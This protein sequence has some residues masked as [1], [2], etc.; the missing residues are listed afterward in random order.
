MKNINLKFCFAIIF[1]FAICSLKAQSVVKKQQKDID[2]R[3]KQMNA[4]F[5]KAKEQQAQQQA[6][7]TKA[8]YQ[9]I[10]AAQQKNEIKSQPTSPATKENN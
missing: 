2:Q 3:K 7:K 1:S 10:P 6:E 4:V 9:T 5:Q 8:D